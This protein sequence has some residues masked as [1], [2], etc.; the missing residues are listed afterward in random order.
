MTPVSGYEIENERDATSEAVLVV[1]VVVVAEEIVGE[2]VLGRG[3]V[4]FT[5]RQVDVAH[6]F[7][8]VEQL[9]V[10]DFV[11]EAFHMLEFVLSSQI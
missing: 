9:A 6:A 10:E 2:V 5:R 7:E 4:D 3:H 11:P 8:Q 1:N